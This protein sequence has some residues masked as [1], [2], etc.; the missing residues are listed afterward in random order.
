[1]KQ[2]AQRHRITLMEDKTKDK[3]EGKKSISIV[4]DHP[5][6]RKSLAT[7]FTETGRWKV[8]DTAVSL[9]EAADL[10]AAEETADCVLA[11]I[12]LLDIQLDGTWG[13]DLIPRLRER[14]GKA[15]LPCVV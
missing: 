7:W 5:V 1:M 12:L 3:T 10:L 2:I 14:L 8:T 9:E 4:E 15:A 11:D 6:M 13:L